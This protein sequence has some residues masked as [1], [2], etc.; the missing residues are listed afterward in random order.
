MARVVSRERYYSEVSPLWI[1][2]F[3]QARPFSVRILCFKV[4]V[5]GGREGRL[6]CAG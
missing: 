2:G 4:R 3:L 5:C 6:E 1:A